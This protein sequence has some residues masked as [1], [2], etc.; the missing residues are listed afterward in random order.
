MNPAAPTR[1]AGP[2]RLAE[3][4]WR[5]SERQRRGHRMAAPVGCPNLGRIGDDAAIQ[6]LER[7]QPRP[8]F[9]HG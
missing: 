3:G 4:A 7:I 9:H 8:H 1:F 6:R 5:F 2:P